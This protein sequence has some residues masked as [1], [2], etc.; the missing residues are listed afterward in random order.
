MGE[1]ELAT[2]A[3]VATTAS[4]SYM[5]PY[6]VGVA[7]TTR[8]GNELGAGHRSKAQLAAWV[9][10]CIGICISLLLSTLLLSLRTHW[11]TLFT[12]DESVSP[13]VARVLLV[14]G[15][16]HILDGLQSI[17]S[18]VVRGLGKQLIAALASFV[19]FYVVGIPLAMIFAFPAGAGL[20]GMWGG[21]AC[22]LFCC[23][24][25]YCYICYKSE[26]SARD[27]AHP[28]T[29]DIALLD[30]SGEFDEQDEEDIESGEQLDGDIT[31][32]SSSDAL[33]DVFQLADSDDEDDPLN[34]A[35]RE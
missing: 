35:L 13:L 8:V 34:E 2:H 11:S 22:A 3:I 12:D 32:P 14:Y 27:T 15:S 21:L 6:G 30:A 10:L 7:A 28:R 16:F 24:S 9:S 31:V 29:Q 20:V 5:I 25:S 1:A 4:L 33:H 23:V 18:G 19:S 17:V 26:W